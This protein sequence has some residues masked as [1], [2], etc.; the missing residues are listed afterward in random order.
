[1][2]LAYR[3]SR[4]FGAALLVAALGLLT[5]A[6]IA[7]AAPPSAVPVSIAPSAGPS[8]PAPDQR[9]EGIIDPEGLKRARIQAPSFL[10]NKDGTPFR[11]GQDTDPL[12]KAPDFWRTLFVWRSALRPPPRAATQVP[13]GRLTPMVVPASSPVQATGSAPATLGSAAPST[14]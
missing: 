6:E 11:V 5:T 4:P 9:L 2:D 14:P 3:T 12:G 1:M 13:V 7:G 10:R 8:L